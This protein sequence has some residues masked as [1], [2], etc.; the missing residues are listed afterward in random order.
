[1]IRKNDMKV[2]KCENPDSS[3]FQV[4]YWP[5]LN[6]ELI[7]SFSSTTGTNGRGAQD[8]QRSTPQSSWESVSAN[9]H[10]RTACSARGS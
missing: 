7:Q 9:R 2:S 4:S 6:V 5:K 1:M 10:Q 3:L 8:L